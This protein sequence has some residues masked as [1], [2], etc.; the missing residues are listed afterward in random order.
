MRQTEEENIAFLFYTHPDF[1]ERLK[2]FDALPIAIYHQGNV[3]LSH[4]RI[5]GIVG[6]RKPTRTG[7]IWCERLVEE[8]SSMNVITVS[9]LAY[10]IDACAHRASLKADIPTLAVLG[11]GLKKMYPADHRNLARQITQNGALISQFPLFREAEKEF[12]PIRNHVIAALCHV[13]VVVQTPE[14]GGSMIT[15]EI[16]NNYHRDVFA[17]PG[18]PDQSKHKGCN[19]LIKSHKAALIENVDD[20]VHLMNWDVEKKDNQLNMFNTLSPDQLAYCNFLKER[21]GTHID[22]LI[23]HFEQR[24]S[25]VSSMLLELECMGILR[26][27]PGYRFSI[28]S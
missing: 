27:L 26:S 21:P 25:Q 11:N 16:A 9:G 12:F 17:V 6:T 28:I 4:P 20:M 3:K 19:A 15:A 8:L 13:L 14:R 1:P 24:H 23:R 18:S 2:Q 22:E 5:V 10:G 7:Q